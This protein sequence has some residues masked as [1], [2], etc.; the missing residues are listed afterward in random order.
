MKT[1]L[2]MRMQFHLST[3]KAAGLTVRRYRESSVSEQEATE[4]PVLAAALL[5][6]VNPSLALMVRAVRRHP[7]NVEVRHILPP[8]CSSYITFNADKRSRW[9]Q[10]VGESKDKGST[11]L[12]FCRLRCS[13]AVWI[14]ALDFH[15]HAWALTECRRSGRGTSVGTGATEGTAARSQGAR[16]LPGENLERRLLHG[17]VRDSCEQKIKTQIDISRFRHGVARPISL[18]DVMCIH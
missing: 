8:L 4:T 18:V 10:L 6:T 1:P 17:L 14:P 5:P 13:C 16:P 11:L 3:E 2:K 12:H 9:V 7:G 15:H